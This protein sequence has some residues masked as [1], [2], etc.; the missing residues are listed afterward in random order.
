VAEGRF[1]SRL[2]SRYPHMGV[3][4]VV[5]WEEYIK[6]YADLWDSF[7]YDIR[8]G[9]GREPNPE[10]DPMWHGAIRKN[11]QFRIDAVGFRAGRATIFEVKPKA[12][13]SAVGQLMV[14]RV[15]FGE[16][17]PHVSLDGTVLVAVDVHP[18]VERLLP[19][20]GLEFVK[21]TLPLAE[22]IPDDDVDELDSDEDD[23]LPPFDE[24]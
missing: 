3:E 5:V 24:R 23:D 17:Y 11:S 7:D 14:Y 18:D 20:F 2:L 6:A 13:L 22:G 16:E 4:D 10:V 8:V 9:R 19:L 1:D 15:L 12:A 21:V